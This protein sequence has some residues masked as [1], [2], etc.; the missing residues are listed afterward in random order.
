MKQFTLLFALVFHLLNSYSQNNHAKA[1]TI[2]ETIEFRSQILQ[3]NRTLN[4]YLPDSYK[5][6]SAVNY[7]VIYLLDG[8]RHEDFVHI[9]GLVQFC[10]FPWLKFI[11]E[12]I[13]VGIGNI[14]R[15]KDFTFPTTVPEDKAS[16]PTTG[17]SANFMEYIEKEVKPMM[18]KEYKVDKQGTLIG[19]SLGGLLATE[20]LLKKPQLFEKYII[21]SPSLWWDKESLLNL[22]PEKF[23]TDRTV[24]IA[25]GKEGEMMERVAD[26]LYKQLK[27]ASPG[28]DR[29]Y[30]RFFEDKNHG[31]ALHLAVYDSFEKMFR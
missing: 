25:V 19:Q 12:T 13:V 27:S 31:D 10:S 23:R 20:I 4:I 24:Y 2:G 1:F 5:K 28:N 6:D 26:R 7:P 14:D 30:F 9:A 21:I 17:A 18:E 22:T 15:K 8:S 16:F 3:E 29:L 11:P